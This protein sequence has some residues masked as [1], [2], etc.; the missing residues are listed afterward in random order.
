MRLQCSKYKAP[1]SVYTAG[2]RDWLKSTG[3]KSVIIG[4]ISIDNC[5]LAT[6]LDLLRDGYKVYFVVDV[7][8][9]NSKLAEDMAVA[10]FRN[11]GAVPVI[12]LNVAT[13]IAEDFN[14]PAGK[15]VTG[16]IQQHWPAST[17]GAIDDLTTYG[18]GMQL[19][20]DAH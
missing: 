20:K 3:R 15:Q 13:E 5:T 7:S 12:W 6:S 9:T 16:L 4:G 8:G 18:S 17:K 19:P 1:A 11:A 2:F 10:R 14:T